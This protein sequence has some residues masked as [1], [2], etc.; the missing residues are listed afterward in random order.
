MYDNLINLKI[1]L[2]FSC[3]PFLLGTHWIIINAGCPNYSYTFD[4]LTKIL[5]IFEVFM[6][7]MRS[8]NSKDTNGWNNFIYLW[9]F[10]VN[11]IFV[12]INHAMIETLV[13]IPRQ[14]WA[15]TLLVYKVPM[16]ISLEHLLMR[17]CPA[18]QLN[19]KHWNWCLHSDTVFESMD[20]VTTKTLK[21]F[22]PKLN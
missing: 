17:A 18:L 10:R 2:K 16:M 7:Y 9:V 1:C 13:P 4:H 20:D 21:T 15:L 19:M 8:A 3:F 6:V 12:I 22:K 14:W 11:Y 5:Q